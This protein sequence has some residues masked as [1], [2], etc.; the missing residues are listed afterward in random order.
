MQIPLAATI[1]L[2][3]ATQVTAQPNCAPRDTITTQMAEKW[4]EVS[5]GG[6]LQSD[7][8]IY[9]VWSNKKTSTWTIVVTHANGM[10]CVMATGNHWT[11]NPAF[12]K[13]FDEDA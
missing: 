5:Q 4:G 3:I 12:D 10:T 2:L 13:S 6:G 11:P 9:E 7:N 1:L 8:R